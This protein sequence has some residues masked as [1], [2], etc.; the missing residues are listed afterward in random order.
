M[1]TMLENKV[2]PKLRFSS[3]N[4][5]WNKIGL[6]NIAKNISSGKSKREDSG[7][8][9]L[10][11]STG[12]I[13]LCLSYS[14]KGKYILVARVGANAGLLNYVNGSFGVSDNTLVLDLNDESCIDFIFYYLQSYKLSRLAF[15]S[16][17]PLI[18]AGQI[19]KLKLNLPSLLE[20]EKIASF[21]SAVDEKIQQ[22][23]KKKEL[24]EDYKKGIM[25]KIFSQEIRFKDDN[26]NKY[27]DWEEKKLGE[28]CKI[29]GRIGFRGYTVKDI[30]KKGEGAITIG[31]SDITNN[32]ISFDNCTYISW[33][34][35]E[36]SPEIK[37]FNNDIL[38][39]KTASIGK[40]AIVKNLNY[41]ATIN[42][43]FVVLK[44]VTL[45]N[46][47]LYYFMNYFSFKRQIKRIAAGGVLLTISQ[48]HLNKLIISSPII[49]EQA[50]IASFLIELDNKIE[51]IN[52]QLEK[53]KEF[54]KG[55]LQQMFV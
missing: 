38:L 37:I 5:S 33:D 43:Q 16:G 32:K 45:D 36:E 25:Q 10:Y 42:P 23:T 21:L 18:T 50:K 8:F 11:G 19:K 12:K 51:L 55:L 15:G 52:N 30:V 3:Y 35:Y 44:E 14:Y 24:L 54:K 31:P 7:T 47:F 28:V 6:G 20:Q 13:G 41:K 26:G 22:L 1:D 9:D 49:S 48:E 53:T 40:S 2:V 29:F 46:D 4:K 27:P 39:V 17:Q 34:K